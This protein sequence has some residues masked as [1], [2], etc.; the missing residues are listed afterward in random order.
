MKI[1]PNKIYLMPLIGGWIGDT[2]KLGNAKYAE[3]HFL[4]LQY[5]TDSD[6]VRAL[7]PDCYQPDEEPIVTAMF[8]YYDGA[9][10]M[11]GRGYN[12]AS[13]S[14]AARFD[15]ERDHVEG[16]Y[17]LVIFENETLPILTGRELQGIPK[18]YA[19]VSPIETLPNGHLRCEASLWKH[20]LFGIDLEPL[21]K[22][23]ILVRSVASK[24]INA[25]PLLGYKYSPSVKGPPDASYPTVLPSETKL[26]ELWLGKTGQIFFGDALE[27]DIAIGKRM[28]DA[29]KT[30][31][32]LQVTQTAR[33]RGSQVLRNDLFHRLR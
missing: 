24:R 26:E 9:D 21:K 32:V 2:G 29:L 12:I 14:V 6:S 3:A 19:D 8:G 1:D 20:L 15:G 33:F 28:V 27:S 16:D 22:Q 25:R 5:Q 18:T 11:A 10:F 23:N 17:V 13:V 31:P 30:L 4:A 7:L